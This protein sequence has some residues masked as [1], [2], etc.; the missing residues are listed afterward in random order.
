A[1]L[2]G[3]GRIDAAQFTKLRE[4]R[5]RDLMRTYGYQ[6]GILTPPTA[7]PPSAAA[8][9]PGLMEATGKS[10]GEKGKSDA[11]KAA[12]QEAQLQARLRGLQIETQGTLQLALIKGKIA[13][14]EM[15]GNKELAIRLQGEQRNQQ[16]ILDLQRSLEGVTD[17]RERQALITKTAAEL[18]AAQVQT[19]G[20][21]AKLD[22]ARTKAIED[23]VSGLDMELLRL[24]AN[25]DVKKQALQFLE[26][27]NQLKAQ[28]IVL[29]DADAEEIRRKIA[30][31][32][33]LT[34]E[35]QAANDKAKFMEQQFAAIGSAL[36]DQLMGVFDN[37]INKTKDW[38]DVLRDSLMSI[39]RILMMAGL[40]MLAGTD[41]KGVLSF[42]GFGQRAAGGPVTGRTP[43]LVG[44]RGPELFV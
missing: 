13:E 16:I 32:Q 35:Q 22:N 2:R 26:I 29:T 38:N 11:D 36:G 7:A 39:G 25:T 18:D 5:F 31:I 24:Q 17:E 1:R 14:A 15:A 23:I 37:L 30:E 20:E 41:G 34:K 40:N 42:L 3:G 27:E 6:Q 44:E 21:L 19:I 8:T 9:L 10:K 28:G 4:E 12:E 33:K 43:Y